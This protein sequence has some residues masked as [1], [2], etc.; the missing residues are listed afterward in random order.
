MYNYYY[1]YYLFLYFFLAIITFYYYNK[2]NVDKLNKIIE[3][4]NKELEHYYNNNLNKIDKEL[5]IN[6]IFE[7]HITVDN[8]E[9]YTKLM[10][11]SEKFGYKFLFAITKENNNQYMISHFTRKT[12][13]I[14]AIKTALN[15]A[16]KMT[17]YNIKIIRT[18]VELHSIENMPHYKNELEY[19]NNNLSVSNIKKYLPNY[20]ISDFDFKPYFE[21]HIKLDT[22][23]NSDLYEYL[24]NNNIFNNLCINKNED[25]YDIS[26]GVSHNICSK[27]RKPLLTIRIY[28][29]NLF[30]AIEIKDNILNKLK[31]DGYKFVDILQQE[32]CIYD[33][34]S[35]LD[36]DWL[37][38][39]N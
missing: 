33:D 2:K 20:N 10:T 23:N 38:K 25:N 27:N 35:Q 28:N 6:G 26:C 7:I 16:N 9:S 31:E 30:N 22:N 37:Y 4:K 12:S 5:K 11:F 36:N 39:I 17:Q 34:N 13:H 29:C 32:Y 24:E 18:K 19:Y 15:I 14:E 3:S 8:N 1:L 21:Y